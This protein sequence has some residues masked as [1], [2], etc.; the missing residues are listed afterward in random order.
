MGGSDG[1]ALGRNL[2]KKVR[3]SVERV[4]RTEIKKRQEVSTK[5]EGERSQVPGII[6]YIGM[7][8]SEV[9]YCQQDYR[10]K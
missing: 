1:F 6:R 3:Y 4:E 7:H 2:V 8:V 10:Y 9:R 5:M